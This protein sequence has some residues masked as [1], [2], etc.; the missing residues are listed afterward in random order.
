M[1]LLIILCMMA[2]GGVAIGAETAKPAAV[3]APSPLEEEN[4]ELKAKVREL[5]RELKAMK[6]SSSEFQCR[7]RAIAIGTAELDKREEYLNDREINAIAKGKALYAEHKK[8]AKL[9]KLNARRARQEKYGIK[10]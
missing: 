3:T 1:K 6:K 9:D 4:A 5:E 2:S 8:R 7:E 10:K